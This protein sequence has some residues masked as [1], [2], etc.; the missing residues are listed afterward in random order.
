MS[1]PNRGHRAR[2]HASVS[3]TPQVL[4]TGKKKS[5]QQPC[6]VDRLDRFNVSINACSRRL[7]I[8]AGTERALC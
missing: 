4:I 3:N 2:M 1:F 6:S 7:G 5:Y 8:M